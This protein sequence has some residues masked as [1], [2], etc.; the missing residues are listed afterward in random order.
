M[1]YAFGFKFCWFQKEKRHKKEKKK[2]KDKEESRKRKHDEISS[3]LPPVLKPSVSQESAAPLPAL[4]ATTEADSTKES[5][6][7]V[8]Q[9]RSVDKTS[10]STAGGFNELFVC[11]N[12]PNRIRKRISEIL[13]GFE[14]PT[15]L[16]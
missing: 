4:P 6:T 7:A 13:G 1:T 8:I 5:V 9:Q 15:K 2:K 3:A 14:S 16:E 12:L 10:T 11:D